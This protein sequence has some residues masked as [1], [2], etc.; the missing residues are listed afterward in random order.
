[1]RRVD[2]HA[3]FAA[4]PSDRSP[5]CS[6]L[7]SQHMWP[8]EGDETLLLPNESLPSLQSFASSSSVG[9]IKIYARFPSLFPRKASNGLFV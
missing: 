3:V 6:P 8:N 1:M 5:H 7:P 9:F 4:E 2:T